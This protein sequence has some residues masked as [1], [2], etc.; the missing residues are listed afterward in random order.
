MTQATPAPAPS[1]AAKITA[2]TMLGISEIRASQMPATTIE[3]A[4]SRQR[5]NSDSS[6][7]PIHMPIARPVKTLAN[8]TP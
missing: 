3:M 2:S 4:N 7:G 1:S 8:S 5:V 6:R